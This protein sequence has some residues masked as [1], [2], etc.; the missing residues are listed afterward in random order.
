[1]NLVHWYAYEFIYEQI[2]KLNKLSKVSN[3]SNLKYKNIIRDY[4]FKFKI[5]IRII[6]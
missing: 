5:N 1:M 4:N 3:Y 2:H 6:I